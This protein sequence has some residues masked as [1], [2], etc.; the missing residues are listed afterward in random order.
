MLKASALTDPRW[1]DVITALEAEQC[2]AYVLAPD[3][4]SLLYVN[5]AWSAFARSNGAPTLAD[6]WHTLGPI[7]RWVNRADLQ[8][9]FAARL[10]GALA[11]DGGWSHTYECSSPYECRT[12]RQRATAGPGRQGIVVVHSLVAASPRESHAPDALIRGFTDDRGLI[13]RCAACGRTARPGQPDVWEWAPS[14]DAQPNISTGICSIC[15]V[16]EY[17]FPLKRGT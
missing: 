10:R 11:R 8:G 7:Q 9:F 17:G 3:D 5:Q 13:V 6:A 14:L 15:S 4:L 2:S 16:E 1:P 12:F